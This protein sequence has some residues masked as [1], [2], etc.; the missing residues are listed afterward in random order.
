GESIKGIAN[1]CKG[2]I[3]VA[4]ILDYVSRY[5][6]QMGHRLGW[7]RDRELN[8]FR[9]P[10]NFRNGFR[11]VLEDVSGHDGINWDIRVQIQSR[12]FYADAANDDDPI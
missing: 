4:K 2:V 1:A 5:A 6:D 11:C 12:H 3:G 10:K 7:R 8:R 9:F